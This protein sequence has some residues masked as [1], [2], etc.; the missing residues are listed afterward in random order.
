MT[1]YIQEFRT[2]LR[3]NNYYAG[4]NNIPMFKIFLGHFSMTVRT[5]LENFSSTNFNKELKT[6]WVFPI[7]SFKARNKSVTAYHRPL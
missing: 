1:F 6:I 5:Y 4:L 3:N 7:F 2:L